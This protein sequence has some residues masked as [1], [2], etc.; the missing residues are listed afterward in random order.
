ML[1]SGWH[2]LRCGAAVLVDEDGQPVRVCDLGVVTL[3]I[4]EGVFAGDRDFLDVLDD[5]LRALGFEVVLDDW[6]SASEGLRTTVALALGDDE[7]AERAASVADVLRAVTSGSS[8]SPMEA[9]EDRDEAEVL[10]GDE[11]RWARWPTP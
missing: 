9:D 5:D 4:D 8:A 10:A 1:G 2:R 6:S 3:D 7:L 11:G